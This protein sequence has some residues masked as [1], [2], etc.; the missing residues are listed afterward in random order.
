MNKNG[1]LG[2]DYIY[3]S[4]HFHVI[5]YGFLMPSNEFHE[6]TKGRNHD[7]WIYNTIRPVKDNDDLRGL[8][9]YILSHGG[10]VGNCHTVTYQGELGP[11]SLRSRMVC[12]TIHSIECPDCQGLVVEWTGYTQKMEYD[13]KKGEDRY[14]FRWNAIDGEKPPLPLLDMMNWTEEKR[15]Y[16][17]AGYPDCQSIQ[18][19]GVNPLLGS[20]SVPVDLG[21]TLLDYCHSHH[22]FDHV[23]K[24]WIDENG[25]VIP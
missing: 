10:V 23:S 14:K 22:A 17:L 9:M 4:P 16:W 19:R 13:N 25:E 6:S 8:L 5:G 15:A 12:K 2:P 24:Q 20:I 21:G 18:T 7:G 1:Y 11:R 3:S